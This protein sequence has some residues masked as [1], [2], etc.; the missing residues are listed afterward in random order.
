[1]EAFFEGTE[2]RIRKWCPHI[3]SFYQKKR[4]TVLEFVAA[5]W[6]SNVMKCHWKNVDGGEVKQR[7]DLEMEIYDEGLNC[8]KCDNEKNGTFIKLM[9]DSINE[10]VTTE[11]QL[12]NGK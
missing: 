12:K 2:D 1:M 6:Q 11:G 8:T 5:D 9:Q 10:F 3:L 4:K 7:G